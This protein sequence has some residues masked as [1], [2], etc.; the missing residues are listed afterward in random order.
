LFASKPTIFMSPALLEL[1][2]PTTGRPG[3][4]KA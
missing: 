1:L 3:W 4:G 2:R